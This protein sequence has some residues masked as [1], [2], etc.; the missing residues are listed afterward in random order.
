M[1]EHLDAVILARVQFAFTVSFHFVFPAFSIGLASYL[2][3]LEALWLRT[4]RGVYANLFRYW[5]KIFAVV[6]GM[7]VV[8]GV[9]MSYQFGT[10]WS[11]FSEKAGPV[12]GPLMAYEV[13]TAFFLEA[14]FLG[15]MLFG[16]NKVGRGLHFLATCMVALGTMIS[17]TWILAVNSW[18]QTPAGH[19]INEQGQFV[20]GPSW[21]AI[22]FTASFPYRL[23]HTVI[24]AYLTTA[25]AVGGVGAWHL[26]RDRANPGARKMFSMAM[27]MAAVVAPI[28]IFVGDA[29][30]LNTLEHQPAKILAIEGHYEP[31]P[32]GAS[33]I[34]F[35]IP[36]SEARRVDYAI[37]VP[38]LGSLIL[39]H[40]PNAPL[41]GL[42]DFPREDWPPV[43]IVFWSFRIMVGLGF[44]ML[45][46]GLWS[47]W[48][49]WRG[50]LYDRRWLHRAAL[51]MG[52][53]GFVAVIAG[54]ITTEVG[55]QPFTVYGL[56]R[57]AESHSP[58]AA[59]AVAASLIAFV[60]VY[61]FAFGAGIYYL[62]RLMAKPPQPGET[63]PPSRPQ[64]AAG[65]T[66][67]AV[68]A[69]TEH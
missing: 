25:L 1:F 3:V 26:L 57:T 54:W 29:H 13:M 61:F 45:G 27:W 49:R 30:G 63:Q 21:W 31:S 5:L 64:R 48:A 17:A 32:D 41:P 53:S 42:N 55:R 39:K 62:L 47:L 19:L 69:G 15:V 46:L 9:V 14:G 12:I 23:V 36:D 37:E 22:V 8:S 44:A 20:P 59:P 10:N 24:A 7:G 65:I 66:P 50:T 11:V 68:G 51:V 52:P 43:G 4:G 56:M 34:L 58:L 16:M 18:M 67:A 2:M 33:L 6:F 38:K 35:G 40:D 28:Q 60:V